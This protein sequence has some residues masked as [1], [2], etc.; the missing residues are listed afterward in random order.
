[1]VSK[2]LVRA[3]SVVG[4]AIG[5]DDLEQVVV[6]LQGLINARGRMAQCHAALVTARQQ[7]PGLRTVSFG[8]GQ[9]CP[10]LPQAVLK[11]VA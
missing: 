7:V 9:E 4:I 2:Q 6:S 8:D 11:V 3:R 1:M 5:H 10:P